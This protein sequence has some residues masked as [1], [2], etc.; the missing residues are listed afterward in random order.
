[1]DIRAEI[2][3]AQAE[4]LAIVNKAKAEGRGL[5]AEETADKDKKFSRMKDLKATLETENE[6]KGFSVPEAVVTEAVADAAVK[7]V[8]TSSFS[9][10]ATQMDKA[11]ELS[12][13][14]KA[15]ASVNH[16]GRTGEKKNFGISS[17][18][19]NGV[20]M[21]KQVPGISVVK[22]TTNAIR[23]GFAAVGIA[24]QI[25]S[26]ATDNFDIP[27]FNDSANF[28]TTNA[29]GLSCSPHDAA[30]ASDFSMGLVEYHSEPQ[31]ITK[32]VLNASYNISDALVP[33]AQSRNE[34]QEEIDWIA[35]L[36]TAAVGLTSS[37]TG[38]IIWQ[39]VANFADVLGPAYEGMAKFVV[40]S[41]GF[42]SAIK[43]LADSNNRP[44]L[45]NPF[46]NVSTLG[47]NGIPLV[48]SVNL[49]AVASGNIVAFIVAVDT[50]FSGAVIRDCPLS[51][52]VRYLDVPCFLGQVGVEALDY[53]AF[54]FNLV[55]TKSFKIA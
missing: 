31:W 53:S 23:R 47:E 50:S 30:I 38:K 26:A 44:I 55:C 22:V 49:P 54:G 25:T 19:D 52:V 7:A 33:A 51:E 12:E 41:Q 14:D 46:A 45:D 42:K 48:T 18:T 28:G 5:T 3:T 6:L 1:M 32:K 17:T 10:E 15:R 43:L 34:R 37:T 21:P 16:Y 11:P 27:I 4:A 40:C 35:K 20:L 29:E 24:P 2:A 39:D 36:A 13:F 9:R 8:V